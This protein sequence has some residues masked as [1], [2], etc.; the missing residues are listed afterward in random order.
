VFGW[1]AWL[2]WGPPGWK[3]PGDD[4]RQRRDERSDRSQ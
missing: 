2:A 3:K 4:A 1:L